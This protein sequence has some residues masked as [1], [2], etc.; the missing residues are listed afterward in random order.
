MLEAVGLA[1]HDGVFAPLPALLTF[2][3]NWLIH[4]TG[5]FMKAMSH[6]VADCRSRASRAVRRDE[7]SPSPSA[8]LAEGD[9]ALH[10]Q[11][12]GRR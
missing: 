12:L 1:L 6:C 2:L 7:R 5:V 3:G 11:R 9:S 4:V 8:D 10:G